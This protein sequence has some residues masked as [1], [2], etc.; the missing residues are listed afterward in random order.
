M[1][2]KI[3]HIFVVMLG[4]VGLYLVLANAGA[5]NNIV[6]TLATGTG[7]VFTVLQGRNAAGI[8]G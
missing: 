8:T 3:E 2:V 7:R 4:L 1:V 5:F 6:A